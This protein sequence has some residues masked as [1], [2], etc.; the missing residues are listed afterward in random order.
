MNGR[1]MTQGEEERESNVPMTESKEKKERQVIFK[2][3]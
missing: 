3:W 2:N 1:R